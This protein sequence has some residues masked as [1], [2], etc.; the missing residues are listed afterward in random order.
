LPKAWHR[1]GITC[2]GADGRRCCQAE[3]DRSPWTRKSELQVKEETQ[4]KNPPC[5]CQT[6]GRTLYGHELMTTHGK[7]CPERE[8]ELMALLMETASG[9]EDWASQEDG[10]PEKLWPVYTKIKLL[11][12]MPV[13]ATPV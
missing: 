12:G 11:V 8:Q 13:E 5:N 3:N 7:E 10:V 9:I 1:N 6:L 4:M 2:L